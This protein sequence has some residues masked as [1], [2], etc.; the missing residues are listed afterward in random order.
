MQEHIDLLRRRLQ[1]LRDEVRVVNEDR[2]R[3]QLEN[4]KLRGDLLDARAFAVRLNADRI[5]LREFI[6][7]TCNECA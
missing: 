4:S 1:E 5:A 7:N 3:L 6:N 2:Q